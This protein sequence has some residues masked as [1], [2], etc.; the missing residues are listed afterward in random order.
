M[1]MLIRT[2]CEKVGRY[3]VEREREREVQFKGRFNHHMVGAAIF[4]ISTKCRER[5]PEALGHE[6]RHVLLNL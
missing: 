3:Y 2:L 5:E 1:A 4:A 6:T